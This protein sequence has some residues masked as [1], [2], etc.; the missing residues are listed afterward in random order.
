MA[1]VQ[2]TQSDTHFEAGSSSI[3]QF[4]GLY[5]LV[6]AF[7]ILLVSIS[8][9]AP[10]KSSAVMGS[11]SAQFAT[12]RTARTDPKVFTSTSGPVIA[13]EQFLEDINNQVSG[14]G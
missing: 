10:V 13:S 4:L 5:L 11:L 14:L 8:T 9:F 6:L 12:V 1:D 2:I 3:L 7:F